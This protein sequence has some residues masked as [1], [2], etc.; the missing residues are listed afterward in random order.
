[1]LLVIGSLFT[2]LSA[3]VQ[4]PQ[5]YPTTM[6]KIVVRLTGP[7]I[8]PGSFAALPRTMYSSPPHYAR[9]EDPP[10]AKQHVHKLTIIAEPDA[11]SLNLIDRQGTHAIDQGGPNDLHLPV[12]LPFDPNHQLPELD[13]LEFGHELYFFKQAG[14]IRRPGPVING[15]PTDEY[16]LDTANGPASLVVRSQSETPVFLTWRTKDGTYK[17]EYITYQVLPFD[18]K[19]FA[20]PLGVRVKEIPPDNSNDH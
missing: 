18:P 10:D 14:A 9:V 5:A 2:L 17:Y 1:M 12:V 16:V 8:K 15:K 13:N 6:T 3:A 20:K 4:T 7:R 19:L 11:Y